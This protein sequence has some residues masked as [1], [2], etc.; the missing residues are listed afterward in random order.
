MKSANTKFMAL[1]FVLT[2]VCILLQYVWNNQVPEKMRLYD[3]FWLL[4][5]FA[6]TVTAVHLLLLSAKKGAGNAF[7]RAFMLATTLKFFFYL[8]V[9]VGFILYSK[10]NRQTLALH[11]LF[12]YFVFSAL[13]VSVL[14]KEMRR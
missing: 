5:I 3:G 12:Y 4:G 9:L 6:V 10:D 11:F 2:A 1:V 13:E 8:A 14:Y 7:I